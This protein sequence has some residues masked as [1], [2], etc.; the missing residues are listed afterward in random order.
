MLNLVTDEDLKYNLDE[1]VRL[2]AK[3]MLMEALQAE[4]D[5]FIQSNKDKVDE[6]GRCLVVRNG[7]D[8]KLFKEK[9]LH[10]R[11]VYIWAD[12]VHVNV[13]LGDDKKICLLVL[14]CPKQA[15]QTSSGRG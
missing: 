12:G 1:I 7:K 6:S 4:V 15:P 14:K 5:D 9:K 10:K 11:Y 2:G 8:F 13:R 3:K